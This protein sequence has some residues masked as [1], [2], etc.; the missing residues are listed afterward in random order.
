[1]ND[2]LIRLPF[3]SRV[4][5]KKDLHKLQLTAKFKDDVTSI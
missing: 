4:V 2:K 5:F 1:M 3:S